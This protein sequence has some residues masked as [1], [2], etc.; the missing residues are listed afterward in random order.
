[1]CERIWR[2][3]IKIRQKRE[4]TRKF[5]DANNRAIESDRDETMK[6]GKTGNGLKWKKVYILG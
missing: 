1:M 5:R 3:S 6:L 4:K 2:I